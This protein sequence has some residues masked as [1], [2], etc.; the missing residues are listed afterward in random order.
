MAVHRE[1]VVIKYLQLIFDKD[2]ASPLAQHPAEIM[3]EKS[4]EDLGEVDLIS[5]SSVG[6]RSIFLGSSSVP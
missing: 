5:N 3:E 4:Y 1:S 6:A 2:S